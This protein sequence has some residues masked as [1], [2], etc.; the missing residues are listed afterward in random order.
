MKP[1]LKL[2]TTKDLQTLEFK[3]VQLTVA[4]SPV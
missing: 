4:Q 1:P 3:S 2:A